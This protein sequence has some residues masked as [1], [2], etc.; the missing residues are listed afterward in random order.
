MTVKSRDITENDAKMHVTVNRSRGGVL[1]FSQHLNNSR[2]FLKENGGTA[3]LKTVKLYRIK[4][5]NV[6]WHK[7]CISGPPTEIVT[8]KVSAAKRRVPH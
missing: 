3:K 5:Q 4:I 8:K 2:T 6:K 7:I 1:N